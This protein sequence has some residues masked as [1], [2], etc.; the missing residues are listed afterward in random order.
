MSFCKLLKCVR[1]LG[2]V[3]LYV[4]KRGK[5]DNHKAGG[6]RRASCVLPWFSLRGF[7]E[8]DPRFVESLNFYH[9]SGNM[10][11]IPFT[12]DH[13]GRVAEFG[14]YGTVNLLT[15]T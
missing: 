14:R 8:G 15:D 5:C 9:A 6:V 11:V 2:I 13:T 10:L 3:F 12:L 7:N 4:L 1:L